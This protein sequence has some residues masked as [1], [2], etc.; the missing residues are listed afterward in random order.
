MHPRCE[1][2]VVLTE[3]YKLLSGYQQLVIWT[4]GRVGTRA[5][6][7]QSA[8][9][10]VKGLS[11]AVIKQVWRDGALGDLPA[12]TRIGVDAAGWLHKACVYMYNAQGICL[13]DGS[14]GHHAV[15]TRCLQQL[16]H[17]RLKV[18]V[19]LDGARW[20][21][22]KATHVKRQNVRAAALEKAAGWRSVGI[23]QQQRSGRSN[24]SHHFGWRRSGHVCQIHQTAAMLREA[25]DMERLRA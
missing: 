17:A 1:E 18:V 14:T 3:V 20:P 15:F 23:D 19:V 16:L 7:P 21:L 13:E 10:G 6:L 8:L 4:V 2:A 22:K 12:G 24:N 11:K 9:M 5:A 25:H